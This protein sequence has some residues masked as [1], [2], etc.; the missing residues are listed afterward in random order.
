[1]GDL[2]KK[3]FQCGNNILGNLFVKSDFYTPMQFQL[4]SGNLSFLRLLHL[5][6]V[7]NVKSQQR[8]VFSINNTLTFSERLPCVIHIFISLIATAG[9]TTNNLP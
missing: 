7:L 4:P 3:R 6:I 8:L 5:L 2:F 1:M 9:A